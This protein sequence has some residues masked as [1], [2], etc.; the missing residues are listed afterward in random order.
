VAETKQRYL[1]RLGKRAEK[2][3]VCS[4]INSKEANLNLSNVKWS[5]ITSVNTVHSNRRCPLDGEKMSHYHV[6]K[7]IKMDLGWSIENNNIFIE[8]LYKPNKSLLSF[9][10]K[11]YNMFKP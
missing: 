1:W 3:I 7:H 4:E 2:K 11:I 5:W 10:N 8:Y 9:I 6:H